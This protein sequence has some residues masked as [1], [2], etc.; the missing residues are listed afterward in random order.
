MN[1]LP[2]ISSR[3]WIHTDAGLIKQQELRLTDQGASNQRSA[4][5]QQGHLITG[6]RQ[7]SPGQLMARPKSNRFSLTRKSHAQNRMDRQIRAF[8]DLERADGLDVA[9]ARA[10]SHSTLC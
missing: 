2:E 10:L 3:N 4:V 5:G 8:A 6:I 9:I 1:D 7:G